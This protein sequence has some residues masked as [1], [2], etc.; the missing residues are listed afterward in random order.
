MEDIDTEHPK[1]PSP[2]PL[3]SEKLQAAVEWSVLT[4]IIVT[5]ASDV[6]FFQPIPDLSLLRFH[7]GTTTLWAHGTQSAV[8]LVG[9]LAVVTP[10][11]VFVT[12]DHRMDLPPSVEMAA[13]QAF[14]FGQAG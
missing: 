4:A 14:G 1:L 10:V 6:D 3:W 12:L 2:P 7:L 5:V 8:Q 9:K 13:W 11:L